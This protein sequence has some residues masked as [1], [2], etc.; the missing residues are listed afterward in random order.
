MIP[1]WS[2][3]PSSRCAAVAELNAIIERDYF[4][5][6][7][8]PLCSRIQSARPLHKVDPDA[9]PARERLKANRYLIEAG[10]LKLEGLPPE[11]YPDDVVTKLPLTPFVGP[12]LVA[13]PLYARKSSRL[14]GMICLYGEADEA[15]R[16]E[17]TNR[18]LPIVDRFM[19]D[20]L[21]TQLALLECTY[22]L[23]QTDYQDEVV[24]VV[25]HLARKYIGA[26][27]LCLRVLNSDKTKIFSCKSDCQ[28]HHHEFGVVRKQSCAN[29]FNEISGNSGTVGDNLQSDRHGEIIGHLLFDD[30]HVKAAEEA[31][32]PRDRFRDNSALLVRTDTGD[33]PGIAALHHI[34]KQFYD[35]ADFVLLKAM[36]RI[37]EMRIGELVRNRFIDSFFSSQRSSENLQSVLKQGLLWEQ[38]TQVMDLLTKKLAPIKMGGI[39]VLALVSG[40]YGQVLEEFRT[41]GVG[42]HLLHNV[43]FRRQIYNESKGFGSARAVWVYEG[44][45]DLWVDTS[46]DLSETKPPMSLSSQQLDHNPTRSA[47]V[48]VVAIPGEQVGQLWIEWHGEIPADQ[49]PF[50]DREL[51]DIGEAASQIGQLLEEAWGWKMAEDAG[52]GTTADIVD[53]NIGHIHLAAERQLA[54][55][56]KQLGPLEGPALEALRRFEQMFRELRSTSE[57]LA[58]LSHRLSPETVQIRDWLEHLY[59]RLALYAQMAGVKLKPTQSGPECRIHIDLDVIDAAVLEIF[60]NA[61]EAMGEQQNRFFHID[62]S[63]EDAHVK[64]LLSDNGPGIDEA[65]WPQLFRNDYSRK[66]TGTRRRG[67]G[68]YAAKMYVELSRGRIRPTRSPHGRGACFELT[69]NHVGTE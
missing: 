40:E 44:K 35:P 11:I 32:I 36:L 59:Q 39:A 4:F 61:V 23:G 5:R 52:R 3:P 62:V 48:V 1:P 7:D 41:D 26:N 49:P 65:D 34:E 43:H 66:I 12:G 67:L 2:C 10:L 45:R 31:D 56:A 8:D 21:H 37:A 9:L 28:Y 30:R 64:C 27:D 19:A 50:S 15:L 29:R 16:A 69:F 51:V 63:V 53:H 38:R 33:R 58:D 60:G 46:Y 54:V 25:F 13:L 47:C 68:L 22:R 42:G 20:P 14:D 57:K 6:P 18:I 17:A 24:E 55:L